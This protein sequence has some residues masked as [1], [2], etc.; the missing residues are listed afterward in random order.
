MSDIDDPGG[1]SPAAASN[2]ALPATSTWAEGGKGACG[3]AIKMRSFEEIVA[4]TKAN[5]NI[6]EIHLKKNLN[7][8]SP[9]SKPANLTYD[10][11]GELLFDILKIKSDECI[12]FNFFTSRYDTRE[13]VFK[14]SVDL[15]PY[16]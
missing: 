11:L 3:A 12:R 4:D 1:G 15:L 9:T 8:V 5:S 16:T 7:D 10:Q 6:L 2:S 14:P 13:V